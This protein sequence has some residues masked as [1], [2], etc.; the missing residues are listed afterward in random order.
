MKKLMCLFY[1]GLLFLMIVLTPVS[2]ALI[3]PT[4]GTLEA[5]V[6]ASVVDNGGEKNI[7]TLKFGA[8]YGTKTIS[9]STSSD[10]VEWGEYSSANASISATVL[11]DQI[12][13]SAVGDV[14]AI[15]QGPGWYCCAY[16]S[17]EVSLGF[18]ILTSSAILLEFEH[19]SNFLSASATLYG[20]NGAVWASTLSGWENN[21]I[22]EGLSLSAGNYKLSF[23]S[24]IWPDTT[25]YGSGYSSNRNLFSIS[26][27]PIPT[28]LWLFGSFLTVM[29]GF[30][31]RKQQSC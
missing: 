18:S 8:D 16:A 22:H 26:I 24:P 3:Q 28:A 10:P 29:M 2:A 23:S 7:K 27:I 13:I 6:Y 20:A 19:V 9:N 25:E 17:N 14:N 21:S 4:G 15:H 11:T 12:V 31:R 5:I 1:M 30:T